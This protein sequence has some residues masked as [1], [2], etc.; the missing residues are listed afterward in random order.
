MK[1]T[2]GSSVQLTVFGESHGPAVGV[3]L[4]GLAPGLR[5]DTAFI[6]AQL[7]RRRP[8]GPTD[9]PRVEK[10]RYS[11]L[12]GVRGGFTTGTPVCISIPNENVRS[13]DYP[14]GIARPSHAD[15]AA[16]MKYHGFE[17]ARGGGHFSG[18]V[19]AGIVAAGAIC[20]DALR[21]R[22][23]R[24]ATHI[25]SCA[26]VTDRGFGGSV[27]EIDGLEG[28][29]FPVLLPEAGKAMTDAILEARAEGDSVGGVVQT[30]ILGL[31]AG[32]GEPWFDSLES[33]IS[34][35][36]FSIGGIKGIEFGDGFALA[37]MRGS[38]ANDA[39]GIRDGRVVT[40]TNRN[41]GINGGI[42][43]GMP[44]LF[45][46][47]VKPTPSI[48][49]A[50]QTVDFIHGTPAALELKGR[51][52]PAIVRRVCVVVTSVVAVVLCDILAQRYGTDW[53]ASQ[54]I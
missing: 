31:P 26:G 41:G 44:V 15:Y 21:G 6:D 34:H 27:E 1:N 19:T 42:S 9:T 37:S 29:S 22:G 10:D 30:C 2:I 46:M 38:E 53:I 47:A 50:Q 40:G 5:V 49:K 14:E 7:S 8:S 35:A 24:L 17:D 11:I 54:G 36:V 3:V 16:Y 12:S 45:N 25:L 52:D 43:N 23:I 13:S 33:L 28:S 48:A 20:I 51:H 32:L 39:F 4:D 18:R